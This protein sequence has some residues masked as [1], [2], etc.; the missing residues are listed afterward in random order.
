MNYS[1]Y[2]KV[3]KLFFVSESILNLIVKILYVVLV[4]SRKFGVLIRWILSVTVRV[5][6]DCMLN[7]NSAVSKLQSIS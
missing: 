3:V 5:S 4:M 1:G 6:L 2:I 7:P